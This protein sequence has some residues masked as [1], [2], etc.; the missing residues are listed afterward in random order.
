MQNKIIRYSLYFVLFIFITSYFI[1]YT[2]IDPTLGKYDQEFLVL[3]KNNCAEN[4]YLHPIQKTIYFQDMPMNNIAYCSTNGYTSFKIV[5]NKKEWDIQSEDQ[6][7]SSLVHEFSHCYFGI[8][9]SSDPNHF[10]FAYENN[11]SKEVVEKQVLE[12]IKEQCKNAI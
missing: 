2:V 12:L 6:R 8:G 9:H 10:M 11:L 4:K 1:P 7:F 3:L 5:Y